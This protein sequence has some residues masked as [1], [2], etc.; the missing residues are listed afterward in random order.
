MDYNFQELHK[1][2]FFIGDEELLNMAEHG[3][4]N[5]GGG[6]YFGN[7]GSYIDNKG[8]YVQGD[9]INSSDGSY[10][11]NL[12][13]PKQAANDIKTLSSQLLSKGNSPEEAQKRVAHIL[14]S[15]VKKKPLWKSHLVHASKYLADAA[16]NGLVGEVAVEGVRWALRLLNVPI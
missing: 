5:T 12:Q 10:H 9:Y 14:V 1:F 4:I 15:T 3:D 2:N 11:I 16:T 13:D 7:V 8:M 6:N